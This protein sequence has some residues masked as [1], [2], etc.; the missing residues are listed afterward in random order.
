MIEEIN[1]R[2]NTSLGMDADSFSR[3]V[4]TGGVRGIRATLRYCFGEYDMESGKGSWE[5][6]VRAFHLDDLSFR[7]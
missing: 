6:Q 7:D 3:K 5:R 1:L 2:N 4:D